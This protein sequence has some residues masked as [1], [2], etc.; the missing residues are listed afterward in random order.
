[1]YPE[2]VF[3][4]L[5]IINF[6]T[7]IRTISRTVAGMGELLIVEGGDKENRFNMVIE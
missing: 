4:Q 7:Y 6:V 3:K 2:S 5:I 1:M